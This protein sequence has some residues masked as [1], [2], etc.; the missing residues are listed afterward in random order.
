MFQIGN[1][2][3]RKEI[4]DSIGGDEQSYLPHVS[5]HVVCGCF[6]PQDNA[7]APFEIDVGR[8]A[9]NVILYA[10]IFSKQSDPIPI[11]L[12]R[13]PSKWEFVGNFKSVRLSRDPNDLYPNKHYRRSNAVAVL[14]LTNDEYYEAEG[15]DIS[16]IEGNRVLSTHLKRERNPALSEA[17][18][19]AFR[20]ESE[21]GLLH[22][23]S[24][25][26]TE[27]MFPKSLGGACFEVHHLKPIGTRASPTPTMLDD[28][29]LLCANCHR[30]IHHPTP[31]LTVEEL[32]QL[33]SPS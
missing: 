19:R 24:C 29:A 1:I 4:H 8:N 12:K 3:S 20:S 33:I 11:F 21:D 23:Q 2:Y 13:N 22:C 5:G 14:Y 30:M 31:M 32:K 7:R 26:V 17:K 9:P 18:R 15:R 25:G 28:L 16:F 10:E 6:D 27:S